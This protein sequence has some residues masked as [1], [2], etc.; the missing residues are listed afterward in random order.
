[1]TMAHFASS[2]VQ[3]GYMFWHLFTLLEGSPHIADQHEGNYDSV[4][5]C[6]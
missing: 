6:N 3:A 5:D 1:M 2:V 4:A